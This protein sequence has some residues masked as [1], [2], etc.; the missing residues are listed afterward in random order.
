MLPP[1][2]TRSGSFSCVLSRPSAWLTADG[3]ITRT[4]GDFTDRDSAIAG[5]RAK[6]ARLREVIPADRLLVFNV[7]DGWEPLCRFLDV[8]VPDTSFPRTHAGDEFWAHFGGEPER[9][10]ANVVAVG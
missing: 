5:F 7:A 2:R 4:F 10:S 9:P 6:N 3:V 8:P 1:T